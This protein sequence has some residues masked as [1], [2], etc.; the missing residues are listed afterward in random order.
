MVVTSGRSTAAS[1]SRVSELALIGAT[2]ET[3]LAKTAGLAAANRRRDF[4]ALRKAALS[5]IAEVE[6]LR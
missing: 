1:A 2:Q 4:D 3:C 5:N 6:Q